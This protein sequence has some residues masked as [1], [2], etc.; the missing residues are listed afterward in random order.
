MVRTPPFHG[1]NTGSSPV[2]VTILCIHMLNKLSQF[3]DISSIK[4]QFLR[5]IATG[6]ISTIA[7]CIVFVIS[8]RVFDIHYLISNIIAFISG[9][10]IGY[11]CNKKWTFSNSNQDETH[12]LRY[13][14][15]YVFS[16]T[17][18]L[19]FLR[20]TIEMFE[21]MPE[22]AFILSIAITTCTNFIGIKF[23]VFK[24]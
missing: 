5:F 20:I 18:S 13:F 3:I 14:A 4:T 6:L 16:V 15:V 22:I 19:I 2:G 12:F 1:G 8:L 21:L 24:S 23:L 11:P 17:I 10:L 9:L 7:S